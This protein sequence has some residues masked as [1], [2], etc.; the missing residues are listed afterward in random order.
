MKIKWGKRSFTFLIIP[1]ANSKVM[2]FRFS[3][4]VLYSLVISLT[5]I[6]LVALTVTLSMNITGLKNLNDK[7]VIAAELAIKTD[8]YKKTLTN[9]DETIENLQNSLVELSV[10]TEAM[11]QKVEEL[12]AFEEDIRS[13]SSADSDKST[14]REV[15]IAG[16]NLGGSEQEGIGGATLEASDEDITSLVSDTQQT[17]QTL[18]GDIGPLKLQLSDTKE[19]IVEYN[20]LMRI[21]PSIWPTLSTKISSRFGYR[22]DPFNRRA[23]FHAGVDIPGN[24]S[25]PVYATAD[26][27]ITDAG[28][29]KSFGYNITIKHASGVSTHYAHLKKFLVESGQAVKQGETIGL[30]GSTGR[31]TG[32]HLHFEV[33]KRGATIDPM[34][35]LQAAGKGVKFNVQEEKI[36]D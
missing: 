4:L 23:A 11:K 5:V 21:T 1:D 34:P 31:S 9:K 35:Y 3:A 30:L 13:I 12:K 10:Q 14:N 32:P 27:V 28:Y 36:E 18:T 33:L 8:T 24:T 2:R 22:K 15:G 26:G 6:G 19:S 7:K 29:D 20:Q 16:F 17:L 25:D